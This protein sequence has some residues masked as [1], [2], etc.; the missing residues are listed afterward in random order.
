LWDI[1]LLDAIEE[2]GGQAVP[3]VVT[4]HI[5]RSQNRREIP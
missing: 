1:I 2:H 5:L 4:I 3:A